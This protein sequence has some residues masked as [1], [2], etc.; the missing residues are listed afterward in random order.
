MRKSFN[1]RYLLRKDNKVKIPC[2]ERLPFIVTGLSFLLQ[3]LSRMQYNNITLIATALI[4]GGSFSLSDINRLWLKKRCV[5]ALS[6]FLSKAKFSTAEMQ[7]LYALQTR[8]CYQIQNGYFIIDDTLQHHSTFCKWIHGVYVLFD[9]VLKT[10]LKAKCIVFLYYTDGVINFPITFRIFYKDTDKM[11]WQQSGNYRHKTKYEL[12]VEMLEWALAEKYPPCVVLADSWYAIE[13]FIQ[14]L[15]RLKLSYVLE[16][17]A[18]YSVRVACEIPKRTPKGKL[19][20]KQYDQHKLPEFFK[21][22]SCAVNCGF[23]AD[24]AKGK[25][26]KAIYATKTATVRLNSIASCKHRIV[27]SIDIA[28]HSVKYLLTDQLTWEAYKIISIYSHRWAIEEFFRNAKQ[29]CDMEGAT[30]RS[31]QGITRALC[32]VSWIDFL[33]HY[34]SYKLRTA[35]EL[36]KESLTIPSIVRHFQFKNLEAL[37]ENLKDKEFVQKW[38]EVTYEHIKRNRKEHYPLIKINEPDKLAA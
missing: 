2:V 5:S 10:N 20:K 25:N 3:E 24:P 9:H 31:E 15:K 38:L 33:L 32:L 19:A 8:K 37:V 16:S 18:G 29:L 4:I 22:I 34:E 30:I 35:E 12:A 13:P 26:E 14:E 17:K 1:I 27:E 21:S 23:S 7:H 6:H 11:L 28:T 36:P